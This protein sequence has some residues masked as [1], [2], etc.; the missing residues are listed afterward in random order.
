ML[1]GRERPR[2]NGSEEYTRFESKVDY[3]QLLHEVFSNCASIMS[4]NASIYV[5]TDARS[6]TFET[7]YS[8]CSSSRISA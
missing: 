7:T 6:F 1:G 8:E 4:E 5:R 2:S 3:Q